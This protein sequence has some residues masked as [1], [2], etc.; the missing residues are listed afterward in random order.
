MTIAEKLARLQD[1]RKDLQRLAL[2][3]RPECAPRSAQKIR[4]ALK[5]VAGA[6]R[7]ARHMQARAR[8]VRRQTTNTS[9]GDITPEMV[10]AFA[11]ETN[12]G[13]PVPCVAT[14]REE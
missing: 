8:R 9:D 13:S 6:I 14:C 12:D 2:L 4:S 3:I 5:S 1:A 10:E 7:N 11:A